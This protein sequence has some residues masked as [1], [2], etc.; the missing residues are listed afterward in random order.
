MAI[1]PN[2]LQIATRIHYVMLREIGQ[3][4]DIERMLKDARYERDVLLVCD[5]CPE[6]DLLALA[7][8]YRRSLPEVGGLATAQ[9][10]PRS[11]EAGHAPQPTE[12]ARDTSGFGITR[13]HPDSDLPSES[14]LPADSH[15][16][17]AAAPGTT[18]P[19]KPSKFRGPRHWLARLWSR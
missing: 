14:D 11:R 1:A 9:A 7:Q 4:I 15:L 12:W 17:D 2:R 18:H 8:Q 3:G 6:T 19:A 16:P 5:A 13:P 10:K